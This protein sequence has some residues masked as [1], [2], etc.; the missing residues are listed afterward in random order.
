MA[1]Q[2]RNK[3]SV[4]RRGTESSQTRRWRKADSN[5][6]YRASRPAFVGCWFPF[7]PN[8]PLARSRHEPLSK[9]RLCHVIPTV[10]IRLPPPADPI[11]GKTWSQIPASVTWL[12]LIQRDDDYD[13]VAC[14]NISVARMCT[15]WDHSH[16]RNGSKSR[17]RNRP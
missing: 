1:L 2:P 5:H 8:S 17:T 7:A 10:Q 15:Q 3:T 9:P 16:E 4:L 6:R 14:R 12:T 11:R 13:F